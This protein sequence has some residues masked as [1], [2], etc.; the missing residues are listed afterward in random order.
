MFWTLILLTVLGIVLY[1][2]FIVER[3]LLE[4][5]GAEED[6]ID[7]SGEHLFQQRIDQ[8]RV[9]KENMQRELLEMVARETAEWGN[10]V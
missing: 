3:G 5:R 6:D 7:D 4:G 9:E 10:T 1:H 2:F 8:K